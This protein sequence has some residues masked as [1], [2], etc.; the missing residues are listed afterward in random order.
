MKKIGKYLL[1][2]TSIVSL[3]ACSA[4]QQ[5]VETINETLKDSAAVRD[6][7]VSLKGNGEDSVTVMVY[8]NGSNLESEEGEATADLTEMVKAGSSDNVNVVVQTMG[9]K[10]WQKYDIA[11]NRSQIYEVDGNGL[12]LVKDDLG[13]LDCTDSSSLSS[14]ISWASEEY[15][16]NRNILIFWDHGAGP[17]YG[18]GYDE[19]NTE[20]YLTT[21]E[22]QSAL[23]EAGT[24]FDFIGMDCC[25]M[26]SIEVCCALYDYCDYTILS[27]DFESGIGWYY[28]D[29]LKELYDN[30][31]I[32]TPTLAK[33]IIDT[34]VEENET[35]SDG[36]SAILSLMDESMMKVLFTAW[37]DF[38]YANEDS[39]LD[40]NYSQQTEVPQ[41][42]KVDPRYGGSFED[43]FSDWLSDDS[44]TLDEYYVTDIMAVAQ[45]IDSDESNALSSALAQA[46]V[47]TNCTSSD[48][49]L[50]G[51]SVT[52]PY[53]D[54]DYY[55][56]LKKVFTN[57]GFDSTYIT[58]L[59]KFVSSSNSSSYYDYD[60]WSDSWSGWDDYDDDY[61]WD[62][63]Y[64]MEEDYD[65]FW[66]DDYWSASGFGPSSSYSSGYSMNDYYD[67]YDYYDMYEDEDDYYSDHNGNYY[68]YEGP[69][70][71]PRH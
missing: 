2:L 33:T 30:S 16:A 60:N 59:E 31:S 20:G 50:T 27:E 9:T 49:Y 66:Q 22:I 64:G 1:V 58:W 8:M 36:D 26:S 11:S 54:S 69:D 37:T 29:W 6:K 28:T 46:I 4:S 47:Y 63:W 65:D 45:N 17:V 7:Q 12:T 61:N 44:T 19:Y 51:L 62:D 70:F 32:E 52:L 15:P 25:I 34:M 38:A 68:W 21:D 35:D 43:T 3:C 42:G 53:G 13:Q 24:Y 48:S 23:K 56:D 40:N 57:L 14:F 71:G 18:F 55:N 67:D 5:T 41:G 39:L 10:Q